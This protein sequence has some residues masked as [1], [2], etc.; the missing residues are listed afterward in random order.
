M[1]MFVLQLG[2]HNSYTVFHF[3]LKKLFYL[4]ACISL[5]VRPADALFKAL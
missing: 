1:P 2:A 4:T 3:L 5:R